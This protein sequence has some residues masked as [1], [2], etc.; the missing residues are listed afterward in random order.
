MSPS[1]PTEPGSSRKASATPQTQTPSL[2]RTSMQEPQ[3]APGTSVGKSADEMLCCGRAPASD[4]NS[5]NHQTRSGSTPNEFW[6]SPFLSTL[7]HGN[8]HSLVVGCTY[9]GGAIAVQGAHQCRVHRQ[10]GPRNSGN[11]ATSS[12]RPSAAMGA[13]RSKSR[14]STFV[15]TRPSASADSSH[16]TLQSPT[17]SPRPLPVRSQR[18]DG[19]K[20]RV[21]GH[22]SKNARSKGSGVGTGLVLP[23]STTSPLEFFHFVPC[24]PRSCNHVSPRWRFKPNP[25]QFVLTQTRGGSSSFQLKKHGGDKRVSSVDHGEAI[26]PASPMS[27]TTDTRGLSVTMPTLL[28]SDKSVIRMFAKHCQTARS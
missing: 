18:G 5:Q 13:W 25:H 9:P 10:L 4:F 17:S 22:I 21:G 1:A 12:R 15:L 3:F 2:L 19:H 26:C 8:N 20:H 14:N 11:T 23:T 6:I 24:R 28:H 16:H 7:C 27:R